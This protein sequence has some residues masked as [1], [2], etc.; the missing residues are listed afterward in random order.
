MKNK[1]MTSKLYLPLVVAL[2]VVLMASMAPIQTVG[3]E[4]ITTTSDLAT[5][6]V[7]VPKHA[8]AC[9]V[10]EAT[11]TVTNF[12]PDPASHLYVAVSIPDQYD[13]VGM[14]GAPDSLAVGET[15]TFTVVIKVTSFVPGEMRMA[16][17]G[18]SVISEPYPDISVDPNQDN[19]DTY[20]EMRLIS[21]RALSCS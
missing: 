17:V 3:A 16:W 1:I 4:G 19:N 11:Y 12:G 14:M 13:V 8:K 15:R 18:V 5:I 6:L 9:Q 21:K 7:S 10:F 20:K 2:I